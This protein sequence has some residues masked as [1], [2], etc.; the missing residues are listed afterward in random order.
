[1]ID[2]RKQVKELFDQYAHE[3][4]YIRRDEKF[5]CECYIERSGEPSP[6]CSKCF[7][8][9]YVVQIEKQR[10]RRNVASI[11]ESM[12]GASNLQQ[13]GNIAPSAFVYYFEYGVVP[14][15][16]DYLLEVIWDAKGVPR[17][18]KEKHLI[19]TVEPKFGYKGR[20]E[21]YQVY[22]RFDKKGVN[23]DKALSEH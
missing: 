20:T 4:V 13:T 23:D 7:G 10:T 15:V 8:T 22:V 16:N 2:I 3:I 17:H 5:R 21:F 9:S 1:M 14:K 18:V 6:S 19:S 11:P 12:A